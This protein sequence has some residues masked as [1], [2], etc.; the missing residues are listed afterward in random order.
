MCA[1]KSL[2]RVLRRSQAE[3][4]V[5][6]CFQVEIANSTGARARPARIEQA[7]IIPGVI[8]PSIASSAP[9]PRISDCRVMRMKRVVPLI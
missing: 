7:I 5:S 2:S 9:A 6:S 4:L 8:V 3:R 1:G